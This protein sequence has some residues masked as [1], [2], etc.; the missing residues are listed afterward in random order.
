M[1]R[2]IVKPDEIRGGGNILSPDKNT[3]DFRSYKCNLT[4]TNDTVQ[5]IVARVFNL[6]D[7]IAI[8][9]QIGMK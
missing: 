9:K 5:G 8:Y 1:E 4:A 3:S 2:I 7:A 6:P